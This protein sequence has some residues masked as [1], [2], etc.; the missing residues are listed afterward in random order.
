MTP[1]TNTYPLKK[2]RSGMRPC[3]CNFGTIMLY[4]TLHNLVPPCILFPPTLPKGRAQNCIEGLPS[5]EEVNLLSERCSNAEDDGDTDNDC[6][7]PSLLSIRLRYTYLMPSL[8]FTCH[9]NITRWRVGGRGGASTR[10]SR[11]QVWRPQLTDNSSYALVAM[12]PLPSCN[13]EGATAIASDVYEC[14][15]QVGVEVEPGDVLGMY[16][17]SRRL[18]QFR[19][20]FDPRGT[21]QPATPTYIQSDDPT[22]F[23]VEGEPELLLPLVALQVQPTGNANLMETHNQVPFTFVA[24]ATT[25]N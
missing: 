20:Y 3:H 5:F 13:G 24:T 25:P 15:L 16:L 1:N 22:V 4:Q 9:G 23:S 2:L 14:E 17:F 6:S 18:Q 12:I 8:T 11:L 19:V 21:L 10:S 7:R